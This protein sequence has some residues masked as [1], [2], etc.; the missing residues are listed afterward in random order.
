MFFKLTCILAA[1]CGLHAASTSP[2]PPLRREERVLSP[3]KLESFLGS[4]RLR[5]TQTA[6]FWLLGLGEAVATLVQAATPS[7]INNDVLTVI[8]LGANAGNLRATGSLNMAVGAFL[9]LAGA[10]LRVWCYR[11]LGTQFTFE[12]GL[13]KDHRLITTGP[14]RFLR[15]PSYTG[16]V[17][18]YLGLLVYYASP[19]SWVM[20]CFIRGGMI[21]RVFSATYGCMVVF[22]V[23][24]L[25]SRVPREDD[26]LKAKFGEEWVEWAARTNALLPG[27]Y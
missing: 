26:G 8:A 2:N 24:G 23:T 22:F 25:L 10:A 16:A 15:H 6:I 9:I 14:Y 21:G 11:E 17:V 4:Y 5:A 27:I 18:V 20:E 19:G 13:V 12:L 1:T 3:T 7:K